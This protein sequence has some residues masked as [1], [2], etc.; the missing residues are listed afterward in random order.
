MGSHQQLGL[1]ACTFYTLTGLPCPSCG[2]T[3]SF[4]FL[5]RGDLA[6]SLRANAAGAA[7]AVFCLLAIPWNVACAAWGNWLL[8]RS[9]LR[10]LSWFLTV[11][12]VLALVRWG[13]IIALVTLSKS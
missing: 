7:L 10:V 3:T 12:I 1:P 11:F 8:V 13:V 2:M 9:P 5:I 6:H 4:A